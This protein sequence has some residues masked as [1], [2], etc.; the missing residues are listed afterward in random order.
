MPRTTLIVL[1]TN[2]YFTLFYFLSVCL[3]FK[4]NLETFVRY[5][6]CLTKLNYQSPTTKIAH[7]VFPDKYDMEY[8]CKIMHDDYEN[9]KYISSP[10]RLQHCRFQCSIYLKIFRNRFCKVRPFLWKK[11]APCGQNGLQE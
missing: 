1:V 6:Q 9:V 10:E 3:V 11:D 5:Q 7:G 2:S 8:I 4:S